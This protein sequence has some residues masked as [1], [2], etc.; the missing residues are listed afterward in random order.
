MTTVHAARRGFRRVVTIQPGGKW[1]EQDA[2]GTAMNLPHYAWAH[3][4]N[5]AAP[6]SGNDV[7]VSYTGPFGTVDK[8]DR[9][10]PAGEWMTEQVA[11]P[12][13]DLA[14]GLHLV[15]LGAVA[16]DVLVIL[17]KNPIHFDMAQLYPPGTAGGVVTIDDAV[18]TTAQLAVTA[19]GQ[20]VA[21][22]TTNMDGA[23]VTV[24]TAGFTGGALSAIFEL[25]DDGGATWYPTLGQRM[26]SNVASAT[27]SQNT[28][29]QLAYLIDTPGATN[30][31]VRVTAFTAGGTSPTIR[32]TPSSAPMAPQTVGAVVTNSAGFAVAVVTAADALANQVVLGAGAF[33]FAYNGATWDRLRTPNVFKRGG[34]NGAG[35][36]WTPASGKKFRLMRAYLYIGGGA[37]MA[38]AAFNAITLTDGGTTI[39]LA[40]F[41]VY[42]PNAVP[43]SPSPP[44]QIALDFGN[45]YLS[46]AANNILAVVMSALA[47][48]FLDIGVWGTEE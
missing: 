2:S 44:I 30:L 19:N 16:A 1:P 34:L 29:T 39:P 22:P 40:G 42:V 23:I 11:G 38:A 4:S 7:W 3:I 15:N 14:T 24:N 9:L 8:A 13:D 6:G 10:V 33:G 20:T 36:V 27:P 48:G 43:A 26:D 12:G 47:T 25:S 18:G 21:A 35:N 28:A 31:R 46:T 37:T 5:R 32:I 45:G 41:D 17:S